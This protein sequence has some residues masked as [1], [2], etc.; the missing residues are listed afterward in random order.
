MFK[1]NLIILIIMTR[2][3]SPFRGGMWCRTLRPRGYVNWR[4]FRTAAVAERRNTFYNLHHI[5][6][7]DASVSSN[8]R[9]KKR[10][11]ST[12]VVLQQS[13]KSA[14]DV[15]WMFSVIWNLSELATFKWLKPAT[16]LVSLIQKCISC[17]GQH[18]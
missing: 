13:N 2:L 11:I 17:L 8:A 9:S 15:T 10:F 18:E 1:V 14:W 5:F 7:T 4:S 12:V 3:K 6:K 16:D